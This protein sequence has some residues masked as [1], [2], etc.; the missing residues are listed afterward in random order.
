VSAVVVHGRSL[1]DARLARSSQ[2]SIDQAKPRCLALA[3]Q[4][5]RMSRQWSPTALQSVAAERD[6]RTPR[7][8]SERGVLGSLM[9]DGF[10]ASREHTREDERAHASHRLEPALAVN[11]SQLFDHRQDCVVIDRASTRFS[12]TTD[13]DDLCQARFCGCR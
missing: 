7:Q 5:N 6:L 12:R 9:L 4:G 13:L 10:D 8:P 1:A 11:R 3:N 2:R